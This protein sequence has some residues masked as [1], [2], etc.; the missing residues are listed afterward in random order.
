MRLHQPNKI[1]LL[2][3]LNKNTNPYLSERRAEL[4]AYTQPQLR[5]SELN[6]AHKPLKKDFAKTS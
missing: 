6:P 1:V 5:R 4:A 3:H 2:S